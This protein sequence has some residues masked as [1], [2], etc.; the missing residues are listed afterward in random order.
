MSGNRTS[1]PC[2]TGTFTKCYTYSLS[3]TCHWIIYRGIWTHRRSY[4]DQR[5]SQLQPDTII[6][7]IILID[8]RTW[9]YNPH[10]YLGLYDGYACFRLEP[11]L[12]TDTL[13][14]QLGNINQNYKVDGEGPTNFFTLHHSWIGLEPHQPVWFLLLCRLVT[15]SRWLN[16]RL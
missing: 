5:Q 15:T 16:R 3:V 9:T 12:A 8:S 2:I 11:Y 14:F 6:Q 10:P 4:R 13:L 7:K 1:V